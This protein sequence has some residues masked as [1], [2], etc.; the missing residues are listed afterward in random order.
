MTDE[1]TNLVLEHLR[2]I[3]ADLTGLKAEIRGVQSEQ[4][5]MRHEMRASSVRQDHLIEDTADIKVRL[6]RIE[7]RLDL[8]EPAR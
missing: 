1:T 8:T 2:A 7:R 4:T 3:R 6:D 5:A